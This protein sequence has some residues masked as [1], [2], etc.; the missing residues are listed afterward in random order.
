MLG[1]VLGV[2]WVGMILG[3]VQIWRLLR[4][5]SSTDHRVSKG[6]RRYNYHQVKQWVLR[7]NVLVGCV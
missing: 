1:V 4:S 7:E 3:V 2:M 5:S 6:I